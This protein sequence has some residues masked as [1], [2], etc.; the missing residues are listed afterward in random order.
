M[1]DKSWQSVAHDS[2]FSFFL[3]LLVSFPL[4]SVSSVAWVTVTERDQELGEQKNSLVLNE[5][6]MQLLLTD[7]MSLIG[8]TFQCLCH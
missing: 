5:M 4:L 7:G 3:P 2:L 6:L 1:W 8:T